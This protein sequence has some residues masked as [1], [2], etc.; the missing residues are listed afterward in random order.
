MFALIQRLMESSE[1]YN[2]FSDSLQSKLKNNK[3]L[4]VEQWRREKE[5]SEN[6]AQ[7]KD[8]NQTLQQNNKAFSKD[9]KT[10]APKQHRSFD[11][12]GNVYFGQEKNLKEQS[13]DRACNKRNARKK[14]NRMKSRQQNDTVT[15]SESTTTVAEKKFVPDFFRNVTVK[16]ETTRRQDELTERLPHYTSQQ[17]GGVW[18]EYP[19]TSRAPS[20]PSYVANVWQKRQEKQKLLEELQPS[21]Q[22]DEEIQ[23]QMALELSKKQAEID[24]QQREITVLEKQMEETLRLEQ[25]LKRQS[26]EEETPANQATVMVTLLVDSPEYKPSTHVGF[27]DEWVL[28]SVDENGC[29]ENERGK[30]DSGEISHKNGDGDD[31]SSI[32]ILEQRDKSTPE[33]K[34]EY[35]RKRSA[36]AS[37]GNN[38][39]VFLNES[40]VQPPHYCRRQDSEIDSCPYGKNCCLGKRCKYAHP[41]L[42]D[43]QKRPKSGII[44]WGTQDQC[45]V[46]DVNR[47]EMPEEK[48]IQS[49]AFCEDVR[50]V[51]EP[52]FGAKNN[53][54]SDYVSAETDGLCSTQKSLFVGETEN[55][56]TASR[57]EYNQCDQGTG[58][59]KDI[60]QYSKCD[61]PVS[62]S[63]TLLNDRF[64][65][66]VGTT[67][68]KSNTDQSDFLNK[69]HSPTE[70]LGKGAKHGATTL[71]KTSSPETTS[72]AAS[73]VTAPTVY[74]VADSQFPFGA[75]AN[76]VFHQSAL[77]LPSIA[78]LSS[79]QKT[80]IPPGAFHQSS[81]LV[82]NWE[83]HISAATPAKVMPQSLKGIS[84]GPGPTVSLAQT[85]SVSSEIYS[86]PCSSP[87]RQTPEAIQQLSTVAPSLS[88]QTTSTSSLPVFPGFPFLSFP[89]VYPGINP[90][91]VAASASR[92]VG[93]TGE[94]SLPITSEASNSVQSQYEGAF[95]TNQTTLQ[96]NLKA[97]LGAGLSPLGQFLP[98]QNVLSGIAVERGSVPV[99][100][101][102]QNSQPGALSNPQSA[103]STPLKPFHVP[104]PLIN[105]LSF[106]NIS[107]GVTLGAPYSVCQN[108]CKTTS[109]SE[110]TG[111]SQVQGDDETRNQFTLEQKG[112]GVSAPTFVKRDYGKEDGAS[113][114]FGGKTKMLRRP[115]TIPMVMQQQASK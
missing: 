55:L 13:D 15:S 4:K 73:T 49:F 75:P 45:D 105:P 114:G 110:L 17:T 97:G 33:S 32:D 72:S 58:E 9:V 61:I 26:S 63:K 31:Y 40:H 115:V 43:I 1:V 81:S 39:T 47:D 42:T 46:K 8:P 76:T 19:K 44:N 95:T 111:P 87:S 71:S 5:I 48:Q 24:A 74:V 41:S 57:E 29:K 102:S 38:R 70:N 86:S 68:S 16:P 90:A 83:G 69:R 108:G 27:G 94:V 59:S 84:P 30:T 12:L 80:Q 62:E 98:T 53:G 77:G 93:S 88:P 6:A 60:D 2:F 106:V 20:R 65:L 52:C 28:P 101:S 92:I 23:L 99:P 89:S 10:K 113:A 100:N 109:T 51:S 85:V 64:S 79:K 78:N 107:T 22:N 25:Q 14:K 37:E 11:H 112:T 36:E 104:F 96:A 50:G 66:C 82:N 21:D 103:I 56:N 91:N 54:L 7:I 35:L 67:E 3:Q 34:E 18:C